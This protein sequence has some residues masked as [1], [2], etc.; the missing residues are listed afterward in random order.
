LKPTQHNKIS[1]GQE[2]I[3]YGRYGPPCWSAL[4]A[5]FRRA[6]LRELIIHQKEEMKNLEKVGNRRLS[7]DDSSFLGD[8]ILIPPF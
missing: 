8:L 6:S 1:Q 5:S 3:L 7:V 2:Y 4:T